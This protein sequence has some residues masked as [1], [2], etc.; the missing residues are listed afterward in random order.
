MGEFSR[1]Y[2]VRLADVNG[3]VLLMM[4]RFISGGQKITR[5]MLILIPTLDLSGGFV[6]LQKMIPIPWAAPTSDVALRQEAKL[7]A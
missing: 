3:K 5:K 1:G 2:L 7:Q 4:V 6:S